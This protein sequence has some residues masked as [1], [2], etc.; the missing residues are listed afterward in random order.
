MRFVVFAQSKRREL[1]NR[2]EVARKANFEAQQNLDSAVRRLF[3][4][5]AREAACVELLVYSGV[6]F[7]MCLDGHDTTGGPAWERGRQSRV[8]FGVSVHE[9]RPTP[10]QIQQGF[11]TSFPCVVR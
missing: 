1:L 10:H 6:V 3:G 4:P 11:S 9:I 5:M 7:R 2:H 8:W